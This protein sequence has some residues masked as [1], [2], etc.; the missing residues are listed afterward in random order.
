[1]LQ[2]LPP[3]LEIHQLVLLSTGLTREKKRKLDSMAS[4][5]QARCLEDFSPEGKYDIFTILYRAWFHTHN[6]GPLLE[7]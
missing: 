5:I 3:E 4:L 1:M 2:E 6:I 7:K